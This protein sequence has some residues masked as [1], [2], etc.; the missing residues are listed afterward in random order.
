MKD[1]RAAGLAIAVVKDGKVVFAKG[2]GVRELGKPAPVDTHT[3]LRHRLDHQGDDRGARRHAGGREEGRAGTIRSPSTCRGSSSS[4][5]YVTR[6][7]TVRDLLTHRAGLGQRRLSLVRPEQL[8]RRGDPPARPLCE[9]GLLR[10]ARRSSTRT[11]C[12]PRP[13]RSSRRRAACRGRSSSGRASSRR[14]ACA[15]AIATAAT[16]AAQA[17]RRLAARH[18]RRHRCASS[19]TRASTR[20]RRRARSGRA[21]PTWRSGCAFM[22][23]GGRVGRQ[24]AAHRR[25][26]F[27]ELFTPQTIAPSSILSDDAR[28][29]SRSGTPTGSAGSSRTIAGAP[30]GLSHRQHRRHGR[31]HGLIPDER[32]GVY[33]LAN[34]DHAEL[35]H[36][37]MYKVFDRYLG[38]PRPRLERRPRDALRRPAG[39]RRQARA[40]QGRGAARHRHHAVAAAGSSTPAPTSIRCTATSRSPTRRRGCG[41][42]TA[43][44]FVGTLEHWHYD[45]FRA[46]WDAAWRGT[47]LVTFVL[48]ADGQPAAS[49]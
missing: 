44:A 6:E 38:A 23:D 18:G 42:A 43:H 32:L 9:A 17:E 3:L 16:L 30:V 11:S 34:L 49:R 24:G 31:H 46:T 47:E 35:R 37:L 14:S 20:S 7:I 33:V 4:D 15:R 22:L 39:A 26:T 45:T 2:Y 41:A 48:D 12:T 40:T 10:S 19:R 8:R 27:A 21:S 29:P 25:A 28:S 5:P 36:A 13:A 1:W